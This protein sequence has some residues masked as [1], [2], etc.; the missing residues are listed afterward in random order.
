MALWSCISTLEVHC[1]M[2]Q[3]EIQDLKQQANAWDSHSWKRPKLNVD[4]RFLTSEE[5]LRLTQEQEALKAVQ[6][7]KKCEAQEQ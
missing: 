2:A 7:Q 4:V 1:A 3:S 5:G 6:D